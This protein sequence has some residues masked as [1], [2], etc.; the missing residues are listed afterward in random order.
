MDARAKYLFGFLHRLRIVSGYRGPPGKKI[1]NDFER[2][3]VAYVVRPR[4]ERQAP[5]RKPLIAQTSF[6]VIADLLEETQRQILIHVI[7][8]FENLHLILVLPARL[9]K[10]PNI[11]WKAASTETD[12]REQEGGT[13]SRIGREAL[14]NHVDVRADLLAEVGE[15]IHE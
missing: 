9:D 15:L 10:G 1:L 5:E 2:R 13:D 7:D 14:A 8:R 12:T 6:E 3:R 11:F 4:L